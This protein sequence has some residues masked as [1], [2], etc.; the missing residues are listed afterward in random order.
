M[1]RHL[2]PSCSVSLVTI[3][4][5]L[6]V[7]ASAGAQIRTRGEVTD[8][9]DNPLEG[10]TVL[11]ERTASGLQQTDTTDEDGRFLFV[12]L[13][14]GEWSFTATLDGYQGVR[15]VAPIRRMTDN[16]PV[17]FELE[18]VP[19]GGAFGE[20]TE[21]EAEGGTPLFRFEQDGT[22]EFE[23]ADGE[24]EGTYAIVEQAGILIVRDYDGPD[25][26]FNIK[27]PV[28]VEFGNQMTS[29][30]HDGVQLPWKK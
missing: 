20:R 23:D 15:R 7:A 8:E 19:A 16:R 9:W 14:S 30:T 22:F 29:M 12:G 25:D 1:W 18:A 13:A 26:K 11:A 27:T 5:V 6:S 4:F 17:N 28:V 24:G 2:R 3:G 21:F 10:V